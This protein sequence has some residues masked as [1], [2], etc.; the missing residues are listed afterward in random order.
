MRARWNDGGVTERDDAAE[1][2]REE[3]IHASLKV[4]AERGYHQSG[5]ADIARELGIG[6][7][8]FYRY[9]ANKRDILTHVIEHT[10]SRLIEVL[11]AEYPEA[12]NSLEEYRGQFERIG[13]GMFNLLID[14]PQLVRLLFIETFAVDPEMTEDT[15]AFFELTTSTIQR[16]LDNGVRKRFLRADLDTE[17]TA[18]SVTGVIFSAGLSML[19]SPDPKR[20]RDTIVTAVS[21][22]TFEGIAP[23]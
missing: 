11:A 8:T 2:R 9:F 17:A 6:H 21:T 20:T 15:L 22:L 16:Y 10:K 1:R 7:G 13:H 3:I 18:R 12:A 4:F 14:D 5:I 19:R 23:R